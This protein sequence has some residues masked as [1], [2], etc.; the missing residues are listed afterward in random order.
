MVNYV[1]TNI[2]VGIGRFLLIVQ[3]VVIIA[4]ISELRRFWSLGLTLGDAT[5]L[6]TYFTIFDYGLLKVIFIAVAIPIVITL[7]KYLLRNRL[8]ARVYETTKVERWIYA[9]LHVLLV[10]GAVYLYWLYPY[11][12]R[13]SGN[14]IQQG[15]VRYLFESQY[16]AA[17]NT[18]AIPTLLATG[19]LGV[20]SLYGRMRLSGKEPRDLITHYNLW[21]ALAYP[22]GKLYPSYSGKLNFNA[23]AISPE[24]RLISERTRKREKEYQ[25]NIPGSRDAAAFLQ[26]LSNDCKRRIFELLKINNALYSFNVEFHTGTS[27]AIELAISRIARPLTVILS[28]YEHPSEAKVVAWLADQDTQINFKTLT[29][30]PREVDRANWEQQEREIRTQLQREVVDTS[31][32]YLFV[33]SE[34]SY[35]TGNVIPVQ[36]LVEKLR[37]INSINISFLI[38]ASH[39]VGNYRE[40]FGEGQL[41]LGQCDSY[42][43]GS[44]K[45]LLSSEPGGITITADESLLSSKS[46]YDLWKDDLPDTT[47]GSLRIGSFLSSLEVILDEVGLDNLFSLSQLMRDDFISSV[48][49]KFHVVGHSTDQTTSNLIAIKP[50]DGY[51][52]IHGSVTDLASHLSRAGI[53]CHVIDKGDDS[54]WVRLSFLYFITYSDIK[55]LRRIL[56]SSIRHY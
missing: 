34:V 35:A 11:M 16:Y 44:H 19:A 43:F 31:R 45:W 3:V 50:Q 41:K 40:A 12:Q 30:D 21:L 22:E 48:S 17:I 25:Q 9:A 5:D 47:I 14:S 54:L 36:R 52:W 56:E 42:V 1:F 7:L 27:R 26:K 23:G 29:L 8:R 6:T 15:D 18:Y 55:K 32:N 13:L 10:A 37:T 33:V 51:R 24:I 4:I 28:P 39:S 53:N 46:S 2:W 49:K 20:L 38:D